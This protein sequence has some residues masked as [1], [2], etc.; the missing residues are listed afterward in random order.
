MDRTKGVVD[1]LQA[2]DI[3]KPPFLYKYYAF[4]EWTHRIFE[5]NEIYLSSPESFNDPFD[6]KI[7]FIYEGSRTDRK[8]FLKE[9]SKK[10]RPELSRK[11][12]LVYEKSIRK[13][14]LDRQRVPEVVQKDFIVIR[15]RIGVFCMSEDK[16]NILMWSHY[17]NENAGFCL[18][19]RTNN[20]FFSRAHPVEYDRVLPYLNLLEPIWDKLITKV[21]L[22]LL[23][24]A[25]DW[26]YEKE[27]RIV[28][29][30]GVG[31]HEYPSEA[32]N[33]VILGCKMS[34]ENKKRIKEWCCAREHRPALYEAKEKEQ[35]FGFDII[36]LS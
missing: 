6:S 7:R 21:T 4:D 26:A 34:P 2:S 15:N 8:R 12:L 23:T 33:S 1:V 32:L 24:K 28:D 14:G 27:W 16:K 35:E 10:H 31:I 9:W 17:A 25:Q 19:F 29:V 20:A 18:E 30:N 13:T 5:N 22:G 36:S 11:E 3:T